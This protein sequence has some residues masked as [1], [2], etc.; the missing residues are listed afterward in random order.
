MSLRDDEGKANTLSQ[1]QYMMRHRLDRMTGRQMIASWIL[2]VIL[3]VML[4]G[5]LLKLLSKER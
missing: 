3:I 2:I 4:T 5:I 1:L